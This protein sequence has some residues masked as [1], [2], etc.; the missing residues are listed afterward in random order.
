MRLKGRDIGG[1]VDIAYDQ[2]TVRDDKGETLC[3]T[4]WVSRISLKGL[5]EIRRAGGGLRG[6]VRDPDF[7]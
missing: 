5:S 3:G 4:P 2:V 1:K 7:R 6:R